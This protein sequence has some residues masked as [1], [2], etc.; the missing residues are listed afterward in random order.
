[1]N[2]KTT[3]GLWLSKSANPKAPKLTSGKFVIDGKQFKAVIFKNEDREGRK[4]HYNMVIEDLT[5]PE[6][7][8]LLK[9]IKELD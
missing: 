3:T 4:P 6:D 9:E 1:M 5:T 2:E 7:E 8:K